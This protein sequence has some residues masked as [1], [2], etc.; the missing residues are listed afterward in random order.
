MIDL[1]N[2]T[3]GI[4]LAEEASRTLHLTYCTTALA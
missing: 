2:E 1:V 3:F 4:P